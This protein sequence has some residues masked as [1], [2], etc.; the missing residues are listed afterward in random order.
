MKVTKLSGFPEFLPAERIV[1]ESVHAALMV[2]GRPH[3]SHRLGSWSRSVARAVLDR[4]F[5]PLVIA[6]PSTSRPEDGGR[7]EARVASRG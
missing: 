2:V 3:R 7:P 6:P 5:C 1:E 4:S